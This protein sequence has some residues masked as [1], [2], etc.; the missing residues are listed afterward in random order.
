MQLME[1]GRRKGEDDCFERGRRA[2]LSAFQ[3][4]LAFRR[5]G[6]GRRRG[7]GRGRSVSCLHQLPTGVEKSRG[8]SAGERTANGRPC[9]VSFEKKIANFF[10]SLITN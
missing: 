7:G 1:R 6:V 3:T 2:S 10:L 8:V 9:L 5:R 4:R